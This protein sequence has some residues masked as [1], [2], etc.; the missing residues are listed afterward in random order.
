VSEIEAMRAVDEALMG[1][2]DEAQG[3]VL[4]WA[5]SKFAEGRTDRLRSL[6]KEDKELE[7]Q[8]IDGISRMMK[9]VIEAAA[10]L[11]VAPRQLIFLIERLARE[12]EADAE[13]EVEKEQS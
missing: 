3:R 10:Q 9:A 4:D 7:K 6:R 5:V 11:N 2:D 13:A 12:A 1:L 8:A